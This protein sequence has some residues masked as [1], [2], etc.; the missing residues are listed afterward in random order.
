MKK[1]FKRLQ[2]AWDT[3]NASPAYQ[4][5]RAGIQACPKGHHLL[6]ERLD[7]FRETGEAD[8]VKIREATEKWMTARDDCPHCSKV[9]AVLV[10]SSDYKT[11]RKTKRKLERR[12][13]LPNLNM[14]VVE[15]EEAEI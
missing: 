5:W 8:V 1:Y 11:F 15:N 4:A 3:Y 12:L 13:G 14:L 7:R 9:Q 6:I 2:L 10:A